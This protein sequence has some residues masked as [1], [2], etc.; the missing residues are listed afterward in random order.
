MALKI[1]NG[2]DSADRSRYGQNNVLL[3]SSLVVS[4]DYGSVIT[5][6]ILAA[7]YRRPP[8]LGGDSEM[9]TDPQRLRSTGSDFHYRSTSV[10][11]LRYFLRYPR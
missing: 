9:L 2:F 11:S 1:S 8:L 3:L 5:G 6:I 4:A 10:I 7:P